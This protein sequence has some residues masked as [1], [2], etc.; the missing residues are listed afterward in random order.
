MDILLAN[1]IKNNWLLLTLFHPDSYLPPPT[2]LF[3]LNHVTLN[4]IVV[5]FLYLACLV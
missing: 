5:H 3:S 2:D 1:Y 4:L